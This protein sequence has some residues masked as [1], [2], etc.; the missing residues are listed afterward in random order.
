VRRSTVDA[1][2]GA[3]REALR[4]L[5]EQALDDADAWT[6]WKAL[7][8]IADIG[9]GTSRAVVDART[10][11]PDFRVRLEALRVRGAEPDA[12]SGS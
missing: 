11:D 10:E 9:L 2:A 7:R 5:L 3:G 8:G 12:A 6:R 4:P 1:I